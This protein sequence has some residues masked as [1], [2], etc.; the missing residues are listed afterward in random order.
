MGGESGPSAEVL[1][2]VAASVVSIKVKATKPI[3]HTDT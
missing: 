2:K 3:I 1:E